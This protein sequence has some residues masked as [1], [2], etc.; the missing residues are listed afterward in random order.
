MKR[1]LD[2]GAEVA[3]WFRVNRGA[4]H[5]FDRRGVRGSALDL[6]QHRSGYAS[7]AGYTESNR[8]RIRHANGDRFEPNRGH[9]VITYGDDHSDS[10]R[11]GTNT[12]AC[13][14]ADGE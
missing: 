11:A 7:F 10:Q 2:K 8:A 4:H 1:E 3:E 14:H 12:D 13:Q 9:V 6:N 5:T